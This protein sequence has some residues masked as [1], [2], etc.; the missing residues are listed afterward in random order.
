MTADGV[1]TPSV[2]T[3][4]LGCTGES[5]HAASAAAAVSER[6]VRAP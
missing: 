4:A 3:F 6:I 1:F 5:S 2:G